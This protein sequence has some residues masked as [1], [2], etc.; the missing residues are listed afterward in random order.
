LF[1]TGIVFILG[2]ICGFAMY[3][4]RNII[5]PMLIHAGADL[6]I[7]IPIFASYRPEFCSRTCFLIN[8]DGR[9]ID[10]FEIFDWKSHIAS[11]N[12]ILKYKG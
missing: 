7:I 1:F 2:V 8:P 9:I 6:M 4:T 12:E 5:A 3:Y 10:R 11:I